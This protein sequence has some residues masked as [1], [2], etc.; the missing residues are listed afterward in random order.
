MKHLATIMLI[1]AIPAL[2]NAQVL[3]PDTDGVFFALAHNPDRLIQL[4]RQT[5]T[6]HTSA[7]WVG[8]GATAKSTS[9]FKPGKSPV[10][11]S[12]GTKEFIVRSPFAKSSADFAMFYALRSLTVKAS[13]REL[14]IAKSH[15]YILGPT[16]STSNLAEGEVPVTITRY[17]EHSLKIVPTQPLRPGEYALSSRAAFLNL[18]CFGVDE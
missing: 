8:I 4:E 2:A 17:G 18:F 10:R 5:A 11:L 16:D 12:S 3:E 14:V 6:I 13:K 7:K 15:A 1:V 9:E